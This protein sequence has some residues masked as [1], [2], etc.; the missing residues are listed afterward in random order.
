LC[1]RQRLDHGQ[2]GGTVIE[3]ILMCATPLAS[4]C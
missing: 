1:K 4:R 2:A 3:G